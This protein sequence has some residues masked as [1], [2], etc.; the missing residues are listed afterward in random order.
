MRNFI[1]LAVALSVARLSA[2]NPGLPFPQASSDLPAD[3]AAHFGA[4]PNGMRYVILPNHEPRD[5][6]SLRLLVLSGSLEE[7]DDQRGLAHYLEHMAFNGSTHYPPDSLV[8][9]FQ[10]MGMNFGGDTNAH[11][12]FDRTIYQ[13]DLPHSDDA[14]IAEGLQVFAD[15]AGGLLLTP[16]MVEKERPIILSEKRTRDSVEFREYVAWVKFALAGTLFPDRIVIGEK[17]DIDAATRD[18]FLEIYNSWYRPERIAVVVVGEVNPE[19]VEKQI[20]DAFGGIAA[21]APA[22][23]D[24]DLGHVT[25][26][27][28]IK[29]SYVYDAEAPVTAVRLEVIAPYAFQPDSSVMQRNHIIRSLAIAML[30]RRLS[31]LSKKE[32]APFIEADA[33]AEEVFNFFR[34]AEVSLECQPSQ[35]QAALAVGEQELRKA[36]QYGFTP[37]ELRE[38]TANTLNAY[39]RAA[40]GASTRHSSELAEKLA[41]DLANKVVITSPGDA[42]AFASKVLGQ[43]T[44]EDCM[45]ALRY[46]FGTP[47]RYV[48]IAGNAKIDGDA[49]AAITTAYE[50]S[51]AVAVK[52]PEVTAEVPFA[53][54]DFGP[55]GKIVERRHVGDLD[56]TQA[57]FANGVRVNI[58]KTDFEANRLR[59]VVRIGA[60]SLAEGRDKPGLGVYSEVTFMAGGL[61]KHSADDLRRIFAGRIIGRG[62]NVSP[63]ALL[64]VSG[65][66][67]RDDLLLQLQFFA[68]CVT[69]P[70]YRPE[71]ARVA[72][73][74]TDAA[75]NQFERTP[76]GPLTTEVPELLASG[77]GRF[78][79]PPRSV[80]AAHTTDEVKALLAPQFADGA[81]EVSMSGDLDIEAALDAVARTF[82][83]LP[84]RSPKPEYT[85]A[86]QVRFPEGVFRK[87]Y[88][89][90]TEIPK[91]AV[92]LYWPTTDSSDIVLSRRI[93]LLTS[94]FNDR[95]RVRIREQLGDAYFVAAHDSQSDTY[96]GYGQIEIMTMVEPSHADSVLEAILSVAADLHDNGVTSEELERAK[97]PELTS[98]RDAARTNP[99][100][101]RTVL[102]SCQEFPERLDWARSRATDVEAITTEDLSLLANTYLAPE[103]AYQVKVSPVPAANGTAAPASKD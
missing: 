70:G 46:A 41:N 37:T 92:A 19:S 12:N 95:L 2:A 87:D 93:H 22:A 44:V 25:T 78:G 42:Y 67:T 47:G 103:L 48:T 88:T 21:R 81:I 68:A 34:N 7:K 89:V 54:T 33:D 32:G 76:Q 82:G 100:W 27:L 1:L 62:F 31:I 50:A 80:M 28:G 26:A 24:P 90:P 73:K 84:K 10:R 65:P 11:T 60:G 66:T 69:D 20:S 57:V 94:V 17:S 85:D 56:I 6:V 52:A 36:T 97:K 9:F 49:A 59:L 58:K 91:A 23:P 79:L 8:K 14:T 45:A 55:T 75:Y 96:K 64:L 61:G 51:G 98:I 101:L 30:N 13:I 16:A 18:K 5:R 4:L 39:K 74:L 102:A 77:D 63:D 43:V 35:W 15:Y 99:Y 38:A 40:E 72:A 71:A 29:A 3:P 86:R 53:Y 83:A